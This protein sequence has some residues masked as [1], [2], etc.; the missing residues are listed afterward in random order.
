VSFG[1]QAVAAKN[2]GQQVIRMTNR[3]RLEQA[4]LIDPNAD[5]SPEQD[6]AI[7][8]LTSEEVDA[9]ISTKSKLGPVFQGQ[10]SSDIRFGL[11]ID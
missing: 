10:R 11:L 8:S 1:S 2:E 6:N 7:D 3:E 9:L 4:G 5:L